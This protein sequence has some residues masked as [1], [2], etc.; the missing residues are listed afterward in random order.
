MINDRFSEIT[1]TTLPPLRV[2]CFQAVSRTPEEDAMKVLNK[3]AAGA[4]LAGAPRNFGFDVDVSPVQAAAGL[5]GYELWYV[6]G[7]G[8]VASGPV[9]IHDFPGGRFA[10]LTIHDPF[11]DPFAMIPPAWGLLHEWVI[12][13]GLEDPGVMMG[14]EEV[15]EVDGRRD[16]ILYHPIAE[17]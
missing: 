8:V 13:H 7:P 11:V 5:R 16:M 14:L 15:V 9:T 17:R 2:A 10:A 1:L 12:T 3:W 6:V 4:G